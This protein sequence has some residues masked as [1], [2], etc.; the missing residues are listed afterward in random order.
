MNNGATKLT[1]EV[2]REQLT[3]RGITAYRLSR[4]LG[5][6]ASTAR[7]R[8][9]GDFPFTVAELAQIAAYLDVPVAALIHDAEAA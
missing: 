2:V 4:D 9:R 1:A 7:R 3:R 8:L 6:S 5:W